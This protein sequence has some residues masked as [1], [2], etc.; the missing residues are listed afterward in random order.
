M[1]KFLIL[2]FC[3][4]LTHVTYAKV[5]VYDASSLDQDLSFKF[6]EAVEINRD[7]ASDD[8]KDEP[9]TIEADRDVASDIETNSPTIQYW[10][11]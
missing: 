8:S 3:L 1:K 2:T 5:E 6:E 9:G 10:E 4:L 7:V 11:Y